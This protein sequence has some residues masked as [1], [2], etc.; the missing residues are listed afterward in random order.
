MPGDDNWNV[1]EFHLKDT[2][3]TRLPDSPVCRILVKLFLQD[4]DLTIIP[5]TFFEHM[6]VLEVLDLSN[7]NIV[8]LPT[9]ISN[10]SR[11]QELLLRDCSSLMELPTEIGMLS[12]LKLFDINGTELMF[13]PEEMGKLKD[14]EVLR[15]CLSQYAKHYIET[16]S[17]NEK[18]IPRKMISELKRLKEL[19]VSIS[20]GSEPEWWE[21]EVKYLQHELCDLGNLQTLRWYLPTSD[22]LQQFLLL[23][24]THGPIYKRISNLMLTI[25][26]HAQIT[27]CLPQGLERKF[28]EFKNCLKWINEEGNVND[29][30][31]IIPKAEALF[32]SRHWTIKKLS[33]YN[34]T[35]LKYCLVAECNEME[36]LVEADGLFEDGKTRIE[37]SEKNGLE[38]LQY[39]SIHHMKKLQSIWMGPIGKGS[40]SKLRILALHT[41]YQLTSIFTL[42]IA[43]NLSC[44]VE[45]TVED[46][47]NVITL[48]SGESHNV[49]Y[50]PLFPSL[51]KI[52]LL[53]LPELVNIFVDDIMLNNLRTMLIYKCSQL[54][55]LSNMDLP[56]I[57]KIEGQTEWWNCL[58][59]DKSRWESFFVPL[60]KRRDLVEQLYKATNSLAHFHDVISEEDN[61][62]KSSNLTDVI[63]QMIP[64]GT[65][66]EKGKGVFIPPQ[67]TEN[68]ES[69]CL[70]RFE[71]PDTEPEDF[72][73]LGV[74]NSEARP[75]GFSG[76]KAVS[77]GEV[78]SLS[79][80][81]QENDARESSDLTDVME[82][83]VVVDT[84]MQ[85]DKGNL[86][87]SEDNEKKSSNLTDVIDQ[88][89]PAG[90]SMEKGKGVFIPPQE[91]KE[92]DCLSRFEAPD[93]EP[94][95]FNSLGVSNS[96]ARPLGFSGPK[97]VSFGEVD[98]LSL[99]RQGNDARESSDLTD[100][101]E[102]EVVVDTS[103]QKEKGNLLPSEDNEKKSSNLTDVIDQ[104]I[105]AGTSMEKG[106]GVFI[107][108]Q[109]TENKESDCLS[110]FEAPDTE[111]E[112][113]NSLGV[114]NSEARPLGF[115][116]PKAV[117]IGEVDSLSLSTQERMNHPST[118]SGHAIP[119]DHHQQSHTIISIPSQ[120]VSPSTPPPDHTIVPIV[121]PPV[122]PPAPPP[123]NLPRSDLLDGPRADYVKFGV[124]LYEAAIK[125]DWKA[126][127]PILDK[128]P[129][130]IRFAITENYE[131]LL[132]VAASAE[133]TKAVEEFV[134]NLVT[135]MDKKDLEL[136][137]KNYN[138]ALSLAA[139]AG[140][141][142][143]AMIMVKK[144][145]AVAE[146]PG[147]NRTMP[148]YMAALF[149]K[150][151]MARYL[152]G[153][154][155]K[156][157]GD[158]WSHDNRG[159]VLQKCV[160]SDIFDLALKIVGD[161]PELL[162]KKGLLTDV[163]L[164]LAQKPKAFKGK[165]L[166]VVFR[167]IKSIF[168]VFHVK[169]RPGEK[170]SEALQL[171]KIIWKSIATMAKTEIADII[172]GPPLGLGAIKSYP[173][174]VLFVAAKMGNT[175]FIVELIR[176]YPDL[177]WKQDD[178][179]KTIFHLAIKRRQEKIYN[180]LYEIGA[181]KDLITP[182]KDKKGNNMLH[183]VSKSAKQSR[184]Q[185]VSGVAFQMQRE[186]LWF[187][188]VGLLT[189]FGPESHPG[190]EFLL[191]SS[192]RFRMYRT[193][194]TI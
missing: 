119:V 120:P 131:T 71:A 178:K 65:S 8:S 193:L 179:G 23:K 154:S 82:Q 42:T 109:E 45:I 90:T 32:L 159:W 24:S 81:R 144:N 11:L 125:G 148:L 161:R 142:K 25:G 126:A 44:L 184:F 6:P 26:Q 115:S 106:K 98:S 68:K 50:V 91:N 92:S 17:V 73:S 152:Y 182:I 31:E 70:S 104:M 89:I 16:N 10:L 191:H 113:F 139:A 158:Y 145:P 54:R 67:E 180:M 149:G 121:T 78:D 134:I 5:P 137:N 189:W 116:G 3:L 19:C 124:P 76:P 129:D 114:S 18:V 143:T 37:N 123:P 7:T 135:L 99:S 177:I 53:D 4:T 28:E 57:K 172:R 147:N 9:S 93:T 20:V 194:L 133:S 162:V 132:H 84:S 30:S 12:N 128:R 171:L 185:N 72:N 39:L 112:D 103:M 141:V 83:E 27:S 169:V 33:T 138:T 35:T 174:R 163:L 55:D 176:S 56:Y 127:K 94:E 168:G 165:K 156:M 100:V 74:S 86:L 22:V 105:P 155:K 96:E 41:C 117:S 49:K 64:A 48:I 187:K 97:A 34:I 151:E 13:I 61:E 166:H 79:L 38:L 62:K 102:Q 36:T 153:I 157:G 29:I 192:F 175:R 40:L 66:M 69:D 186:L 136:Q 60:K 181:M 15:I 75:L 107:P 108:P 130:V 190:V 122:P 110:R 43:Q 160:E 87:P 1:V 188:L 58:G 167:I 47:P 95:D 88:M 77:I 21:E 80:S 183:M 14:L 146:I 85:K 46:C 164:A 118:S 111:P 150:P 170:E 52:F 59:Y 63:D 140:N 2:N 51:Q 101:M 173:S